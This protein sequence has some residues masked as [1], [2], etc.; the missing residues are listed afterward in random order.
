[1]NLVP[2]DLGFPFKFLPRQFPICLCFAMTIN[3][4]KGQSLSKVGLHLAKPIFTHGQLY[5]VVSR[6][7]SKK[8]WKFLFWMMEKYAH[9]QIQETKR[10][11]HMLQNI[12]RALHESN[13]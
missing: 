10:R 6:V 11:Q 3:K 1:M 7:K 2:S 9:E 4:S 8:A 5:I 12:T 13:N